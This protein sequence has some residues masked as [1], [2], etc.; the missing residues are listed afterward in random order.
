MQMLLAIPIGV[1]YLLAGYRAVRFTTKLETALLCLL[2]GLAACRPL[3]DW[4]ATLSIAAAAAVL[5][6]L[7]G[8][9]FYYLSIALIGAVLGAAIMAITAWSIGGCIGWDSGIASALLGAMLTLRFQRPLVILGSSMIGAALLMTAV[10]PPGPEAPAWSS[11]ALFV[12]L[13]LLGCL[14][15]ARTAR[16]VPESSD[17]RR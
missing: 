7:L 14:V 11:G 13:S 4:V 6:F 15:Q 17:S 3:D 10:V 9:S 1:L 16:T 12:G 8:D 2:L 5:G